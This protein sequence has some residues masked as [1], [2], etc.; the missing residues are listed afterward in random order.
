MADLV[1]GRRDALADALVRNPTEREHQQWRDEVDQWLARTG[2]VH[3]ARLVQD[4]ETPVM[5]YRAIT[6]ELATA[7]GR[8]E[9]SL[10]LVFVHILEQWRVGSFGV[11]LS[12][13][14]N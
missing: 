8:A 7:N 4:D 6:Y 5:H 11:D 14:N 12:S 9:A 10:E 2:Q 1:A 3:S 13:S